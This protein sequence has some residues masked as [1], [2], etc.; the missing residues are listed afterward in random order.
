M[1]LVQFYF[2]I[3]LCREWPSP[4]DKTQQSSA[5]VEGCMQKL[6]RALLY[7][8]FKWTSGCDNLPQ[9]GGQRPT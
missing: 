8:H 2:H 7:R 5:R 6:L 4:E 3:Q 9:K 1:R